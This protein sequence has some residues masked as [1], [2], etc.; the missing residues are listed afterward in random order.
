MYLASTR[1]WL[2]SV[3]S[4]LL[5]CCLFICFPVLDSSTMSTWVTFA[6]WAR[7]LGKCLMSASIANKDEC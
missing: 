1:N 7:E 5:Q 6:T 2:P 4:S 3:G